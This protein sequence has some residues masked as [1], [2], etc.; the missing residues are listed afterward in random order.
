MGR[1]GGCPP[2]PD[3]HRCTRQSGNGWRCNNSKFLN[4]DHCEKHYKMGQD[5][6]RKKRRAVDCVVDSNEKMSNI[7]DHTTDISELILPL[8]EGFRDDYFDKVVSILKMREQ[9]LRMEK[10]AAEK[11]AACFKRELECCEVNCNKLLNEVEERRMKEYNACFKRAA[12]Q[13]EHLRCKRMC[14]Q[15]QMKNAELES[16][17]RRKE[18][19]IGRKKRFQTLEIM[20]FSTGVYAAPPPGFSTDVGPGAGAGVENGSVAREKACQPEESS[21]K[22]LISPKMET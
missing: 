11:A 4:H 5:R 22:T 16:E 17:K 3:D 13:E 20:G 18:N 15:L 9:N 7:S 6:N 1:N 14:I 10:E 19:E 8:K 12:V 21:Y 2:P